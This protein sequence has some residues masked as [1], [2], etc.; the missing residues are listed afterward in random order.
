MRTSEF[1][2]V[3]IDLHTHTLILFELVIDKDLGEHRSNLSCKM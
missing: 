2:P 3:Y 1:A